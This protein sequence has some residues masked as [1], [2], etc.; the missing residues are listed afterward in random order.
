MLFKKSL[1]FLNALG[2]SLKDKIMLFVRQTHKI[3]RAVIV[4]NAVKMMNYP[5]FWQKLIVC[6][7]PNKDMLSNIVSPVGSGMV[8][9]IDNNIT[10]RQYSTALPIMALL[11]SMDRWFY[12]PSNGTTT[13]TKGGIFPYYPT[14]FGARVFM[15]FV[16]LLSILCS[17]PFI[18]IRHYRL[19]SSIISYHHSL[20]LVDADGNI[21]PEEN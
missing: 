21:I 8:R 13:P 10:T 16:I 17:I 14:A 6:F 4:F 5:S 9:S 18:P 12:S 7:L 20:C 1:K 3:A 19:S 2:F 11:S 15:L